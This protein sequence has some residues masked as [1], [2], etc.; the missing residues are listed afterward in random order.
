MISLS[1]ILKADR[2]VQSSDKFLLEVTK[3]V[4]AKHKTIE[5]EEMFQECEDQTVMEANEEA[6]AII[7][8]AQ[9]LAQTILADASRHAE[10]KREQVKQQIAAWWDE[11]SQEAEMMAAKSYEK[12][13]EEGYALGKNEGYQDAIK[14]EEHH[15]EEAKALLVH[16]H[17]IKEQ[18]IAESEPFL[19]EL[20]TE[21]S[22]KIIQQELQLSP[23]KILEIVKQ[24]L[25][26]SRASGQ[27]TIA[28]NHKFY[29]IVEEQREEL[30]SLF[31]GQVELI[32]YPD[33]S[34][35]DEGCVIRTPFGSVDAKVDTQLNEIRQTLLEI[36]QGS[37]LA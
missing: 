36:A 9:E 29:T 33:Y 27:V 35:A 23:E 10:E 15:V 13:H 26:S 6:E 8:D 1:R 32:I 34:I 30:L 20:S 37:E 31:D 28:V 5:P 2:F 7:R 22:K 4:V 16:A 11:K 3:T 19:V 12:A 24:A 14:E 17:Q 21:I 18:I 25:R